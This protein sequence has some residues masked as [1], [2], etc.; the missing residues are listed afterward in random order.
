M[1][2]DN[3]VIAH[4]MFH[5]FKRKKTGKVGKMVLKVDMNKAYDRI[6]W[7]FLRKVMEAMGFEEKWVN[8]IMQCV[9]T[10]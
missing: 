2:H 5:F 10:V 4:E 8:W 3:V 7:D 6:E 9:S 1:I